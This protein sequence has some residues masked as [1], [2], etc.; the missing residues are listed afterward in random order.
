MWP[1]DSNKVFLFFSFFLK[2]AQTIQNGLY[3]FFH[4]RKEKKNGKKRKKK[5]TNERK[6]EET[7]TLNEQMEVEETK[8]KNGFHCDCRSFLCMLKFFVSK[9]SAFILR[10]SPILCTKSE[11]FVV[12]SACSCAR[13]RKTYRFGCALRYYY[14][15]LLSFTVHRCCFLLL[16]EYFLER[17]FIWS[18]V[19]PFCYSVCVCWGQL[20]CLAVALLCYG[21][22]V[23]A[24]FR[25]FG[26]CCCCCCY[27]CVSMHSFF[28]PVSLSCSLQS[29]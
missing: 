1:N 17:I 25:W 11:H 10:Y 29:T 12:Q 21:R 26:C 18:V 16:F 24:Y 27:C 23:S 9:P 20:C 7:H 4:W 13:L 3:F 2:L 15:F 19:F 5:A 14:F 28:F 22:F 6:R 8:N